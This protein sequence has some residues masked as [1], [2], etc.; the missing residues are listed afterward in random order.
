MRCLCCLFL[1]ICLVSATP[2][3]EF[4]LVFKSEWTRDRPP[5]HQIMVNGSHPVVLLTG[6]ENRTC[7]NCPRID[8]LDVEYNFLMTQERY[9]LTLGDKW[10]L[11]VR[12]AIVH[13]CFLLRPGF[14]C[15]TETVTN[16]GHMTVH[17][18][19]NT[20]FG[21]GSF[22]HLLDSTDV[23]GLQ[24]LVEKHEVLRIRWREF[25]REM[26]MRSQP[27]HVWVAL[28]RDSFM[29]VVSCNAY[30]SSAFPM[31]VSLASRA[32]MTVSGKETW[33]FISVN[34]SVVSNDLSMDYCRIESILGWAIVITHIPEGFQMMRLLEHDVRQEKNSWK[35]ETLVVKPPHQKIVTTPDPKPT[36]TANPLMIF[37][38]S[39]AIFAVVTMAIAIFVGMCREY[40]DMRRSDGRARNSVESGMA[41]MRF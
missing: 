16:Q 34:A 26:K 8:T 28:T 2:S 29:N 15:D 1:A 18:S 35:D 7:H 30:C 5:Q 20:V 32:G 10:P 17:R 25:L 22:L 21:H 24:Y 23:P 27:A 3:A 38:A 37:C 12:A 6:T 9:L 36:Q 31:T 14:V 39:A 41:Y 13:T 33:S 11:V 19:N 40:I 4:Q